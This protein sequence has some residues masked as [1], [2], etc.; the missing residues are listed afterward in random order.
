MG[1]EFEKLSVL[2]VED[3]MPMRELFASILKSLGIKNIALAANGEEA[4]EA[5]KKD[6]H[7]I[8]FTDWIMD[9]VDGLELTNEIRT[10]DLSPNRMAPIILITGYSAWPRVA[11]AR[12]TGVTEFLVKPFTAHDIARRLAHVITHPR[13]FIETDNFFG[14]DRRRRVDPGYSGP[15]RREEDEKTYSAT[16][17]N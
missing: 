7:D 15:Q 3:T 16:S 11:N 1:F 12:D 13:N 17:D 6:N 10:N 9:P 2:I 5:F 14:P 8:I 4:F